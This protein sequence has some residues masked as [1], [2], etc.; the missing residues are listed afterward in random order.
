LTTVGACS[1]STTAPNEGI[2]TLQ[3]APKTIVLTG[4]LSQGTFTVTGEKAVGSPY[5]PTDVVA[6][7]GQGSVIAFAG[8]PTSA[9]TGLSVYVVGMGT[10]KDT[11]EVKTQGTSVQESDSASVIVYPGM[12]WA[13]SV[14]LVNTSC[15]PSGQ[16]AY[17]EKLVIQVDTTGRGT[18]TAMDTPGFNR[19]YDV[20]FPDSWFTGS[21]V[22]STGTFAFLGSAVGGSMAIVR[23]D[24]TTIKYTETTTYPCAATYSGQ[25]VKSLS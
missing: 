2:D 8:S 25:L 10:G 7:M 14:A 16:A 21:A 13:G 4:F 12:T 1:K 23:V 18:A 3:V 17:N 9:A 20:T 15:N 5:Q 22:T 11:L 19:Q 6:T 24:P